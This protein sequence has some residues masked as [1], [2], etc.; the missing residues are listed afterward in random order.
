MMEWFRAHTKQIMVVV[1]LMAMLAF[2]GGDALTTLFAAGEANE[3]YG[4]VFGETVRTR[5]LMAVQQDMTILERLGFSLSFSGEKEVASQHYYMLLAEARA[6]GLSVAQAEI[7]ETLDQILKSRGLTID[8]LRVRDRNLTPTNVYEAV[9]HYIM[10]NKN[11]ERVI[12]ASMPSDAEVRHYAVD[13]E[14]RAKVKTVV[15]DAAKFVDHAEVIPEAEI[16]AHFDKYKD[17]FKADSTDGYGYKFP[18]RVK[19]QCIVADFSRIAAQTTVTIEEASAHWR[20]NKSAYMITEKVPVTPPATTNPADSQPAMPEPS[21]T[22]ISREMIFSEAKPQVEAEIKKK[23]AAQLADQAMRRASNDLLK[24]WETM[25]TDQ[26]TGFKPIAPGVT[27]AGYMEAVRNKAAAEAGISL[28]YMEIGLISRP[29]LAA[30]PAVG[31]ATVPGSD[32]QRLTLAE[33]AFRVPILYKSTEDNDTSPRLQLYQVPD[34]PLPIERSGGRTLRQDPSTGQYEIV[35]IPGERTGLVLFRVVEA[36][37]AAPPATLA[38]VHSQ[39]VNDLREKRAYERMESAAQQLFAAA[40]KVGLTDALALD[41]ALKTKLGITAVSTPSPFARKVG[42]DLAPAPVE[43]VGA[44][45]EFLT[46]VFSM[47]SA[48]WTSPEPAT[49]QTESPALTT[50][51]AATPAPKVALVNL[52]KSRKRVMVEFLEMAPLTEDRYTS[53]VRSSSFQQLFQRRA[54]EVGRNW[55]DPKNIEKRCNFEMLA[56]DRVRTSEGLQDAPTGTPP[57]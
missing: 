54:R 49:P 47:S 14:D 9:G 5:D 38:E 26:K 17:E 52:P 2:I 24:P 12:R 36:M 41:D 34:A 51:P 43:G 1:V 19:V 3:K 7:D 56:T 35:D 11:A 8:V 13:T 16:Q 40:R 23:R 22:S 30:H 15:L 45:E 29:D 57:A 33:Y 46:T 4:K 6:A 48:D 21:E 10:I 50:R 31:K 37:D 32:M 27:D 20:R 44:A 25:I 39:V 28:D 53:Q 18:A 42:G 55:F